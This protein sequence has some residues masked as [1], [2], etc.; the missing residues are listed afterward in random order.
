MT[1]P[2]RNNVSEG[3]QRKGVKKRRRKLRSGVYWQGALK[4]KGVK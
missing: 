1:F 2:V 4:G 3:S